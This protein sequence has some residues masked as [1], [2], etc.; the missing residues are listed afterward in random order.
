MQ[1]R[2]D[3]RIF[4]GLV[5]INVFCYFQ[6]LF[7]GSMVMLLLML[8]QDYR[9]DLMRQL[10]IVVFRWLENQCSVIETFN[11]LCICFVILWCYWKRCFILPSTYISLRTILLLNL[12]LHLTAKDSLQTAFWI[13]IILL[14]LKIHGAIT[15]DLRCANLLGFIVCTPLPKGGG[16]R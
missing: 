1:G 4:W 15:C 11:A 6:A 5:V 9:I 7:L 3:L 12:S 10:L 14:A 2:S 8:V 16:R 13:K